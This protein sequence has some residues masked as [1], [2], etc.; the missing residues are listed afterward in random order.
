[1][2]MAE[3]PNREPSSAW[4]SFRLSR[5]ARMAFAQEGLPEESGFR[6]MGDLISESTV[7]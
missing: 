5:K 6:S 1:M 3:K 2:A 7:R 4:F